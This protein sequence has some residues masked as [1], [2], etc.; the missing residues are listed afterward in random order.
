MRGQ[1]N[2]E[3]SHMKTLAMKLIFL[4]GLTGSISR[5]TFNILMKRDAEDSNSKMRVL[6]DE[7]DSEREVLEVP[8]MEYED[9][10]K[11]SKDNESEDTIQKARRELPL[12]A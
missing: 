10:N 7:S 3:S 9:D 12:K 6:L 5:K 1:E 2:I 11:P 8:L 4:L